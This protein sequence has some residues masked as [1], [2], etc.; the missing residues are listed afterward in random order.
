MESHKT[1]RSRNALIAILFVAAMACVLVFWFLARLQTAP[2]SSYLRKDLPL[3]A[4]DLEF[5]DRKGEPIPAGETRLASPATKA[6]EDEG[7]PAK[8]ESELVG[9][10]ASNRSGS[11]E[12]KERAKTGIK[13]A[14]WVVRRHPV[15]F[16]LYVREGGQV[17]QWLEKK[18]PK[19]GSWPRLFSAGFSTTS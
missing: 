11:W 16:S 4:M 3:L 10:D 19:G 18:G 1:G 12:I 9:G 17:T 6:P 13:S 5:R 15:A 7:P 2:L 8:K 14:K